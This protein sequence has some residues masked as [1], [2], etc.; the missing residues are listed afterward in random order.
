MEK[1]RFKRLGD[2]LK[3][4]CW[5]LG[6]GTGPHLFELRPTVSGSSFP[7]PKFIHVRI[8]LCSVATGGLSGLVGTGLFVVVCWL[9]TAAASLLATTR[10]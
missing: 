3:V 2:F 7:V 8:W 1:L 10:L 6:Y 4:I 9:F 5:D